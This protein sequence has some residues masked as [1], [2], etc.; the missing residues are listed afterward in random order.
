MNI[1]IFGMGAVG[2]HLAD[3]LSSE[4]HNLTLIDASSSV[5]EEL[6]E[7]VDARVVCGD[8]SS[9]LTLADAGVGEAD[10]F[11]GLSGD[12]N[13]NLVA[14][15]IAKALGA[16][17]T[18][19]RLHA[20]M[21][22]DS[23][24]FD[25]RTHFQL[26][27]VFSTQRLAAVELAKHI[28]N[29]E[30]LMVE[31]IARGAIELQQVRL[32]DRQ[33]VVGV[34]LK[35]L[36]LPPEVLVG[37]IRREGH[38]KIPNGEDVLQSGDQITLFGAPRVL[39][40]ILPQFQSNIIPDTE[41]SVVIFGGDEYGFALAEM[42]EGHKYRVRVMEKRASLCRR[43]SETLNRTVVI[44]GDATSAQQLREERVGDAD[45]FIAAT[46]DDEDNVMTCLQ[47][48]SL[49][50]RYC[51]TLIHRSDYAE[52]ISRNSRQLQI[53]A[54]ISPWEATN[55]ELL[56]FITSERANTVFSLG[57]EA[58][59]LEAVVPDGGTLPGRTIAETPWPDGCVI[60]GLAHGSETRV[61]GAASRI[62][63]GDTLYAV[64]ATGS[65]QRF[66]DLFD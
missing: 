8:G 40:S 38:L 59:V 29:P 44:Q 19:V 6:N 56:R 52:V 58:E 22:R 14:A 5:A 61:P 48:K 34:A 47:A 63:A 42:L 66:V 54:A 46:D 3:R 64:V 17:R 24:L 12:D 11:L 45:F 2:Q 36:S 50:T 51:L 7:R 23:W 25:L 39:S 49:G 18:I 28:R 55:R 21:Q 10:L 62:S 31:E 4:Q 13:A 20:Q 15:S 26:D 30:R 53:H 16:G 33:P 65:K 35:D 57:D 60:V 9:A 1:V 43:L 37:S 32:T 41:I 27:H